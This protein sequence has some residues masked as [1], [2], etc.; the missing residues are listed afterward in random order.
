MRQTQDAINELSPTALPMIGTANSYDDTARSDTSFSPYYFRLAPPDQRLARHAAYWAEHGELGIHAKTA[1]VFYSGDRDDLYS[2]NLARDFKASFAPG[3]VDMLSYADPSQVPDIVRRACAHPSD[4]FYYAGRSDEFLSFTT[5]LSN[6][7]CGGKRVVL[8]DDEIAKFV[9]DHAAEIGRDSD[10]MQL[11]YMPLALRQAWT[12]TWVGPRQPLQQ[13]FFSEYDATVK[14]L[15]GKNTPAEQLPSST[16]A[17]VSYD[18][19]LV[20]ADAAQHVYA[21]HRAQPKPA[22]ILSALVE[23]ESGAPLQG[24]SGVL[25]FG[26]RSVGH[27]IVDKPVLL[28]TARPDGV[29]DV[30]EVCGRLVAADQQKADCPARSSTTSATGG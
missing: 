18:T 25:T 8:A 16:H 23:P 24:V 26:P 20:I 30:R 15:T 19:A 29:I 3:K 21:E 5:V 14:Q 1:T 12:R 6:T 10:A 4:L 27:Q 2:Q 7:A 11:F 17:A 28:A 9:S 22:A 13:Q